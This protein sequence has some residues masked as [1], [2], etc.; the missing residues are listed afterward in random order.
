MRNAL[1]AG[2][3]AALVGCIGTGTETG[4]PSATVQAS[5]GLTAFSSD[6]SAVS[7]PADGA[8]GGVRLTEAWVSVKQINLV[9]QAI[10]DGSTEQEIEFTGPVG[11]LAATGSLLEVLEIPATDYCRVRIR[12]DEPEDGAPAEIAGSSVVLRGTT[13]A[14]TPFELRSEER[15]QLLLR[16][17][18]QPFT[19]DETRD[20]IL[21]AFDV[22]RWFDGVPLDDGTPTGGT[23]VIDEDSNPGLLAA[24]QDKVNASLAVY[25][26]RDG[27]GDLDDDER[28]SLT[29]EGE[30]D[31]D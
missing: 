12:I 10:C 19:I 26:D 18:G 15:F 30:D 23:I 2:A 29:E 6:P 1:A 8:S 21:L 14:G 27:D 5:I 4:N 3:L 22:K 28:E 25:R 11:D 13:A 9:R 17:R 16:S 20:A 31:D 24:F 7:L